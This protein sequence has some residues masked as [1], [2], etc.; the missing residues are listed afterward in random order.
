MRRRLCRWQIDGRFDGSSTYFYPRLRARFAFYR[1]WSAPEFRRQNLA[2]RLCVYSRDQLAKWSREHPEEKLS[3]TLHHP[4]GPTNSGP[5]SSPRSRSSLTCSLISSAIRRAAIRCASSG[6]S[7]RLSNEANS[8]GDP[9]PR[10]AAGA[11]KTGR[12][13]NIVAR[14]LSEIWQHLDPQLP[15]QSPQ[16]PRKYRR[17]PAKHQR[18]ERVHR[19]GNRDKSYE[20]HFD[21]R[22]TNA[23]ARRS[24]LSV[25]RCSRTS[26]TTPMGSRWSRHIMRW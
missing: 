1:S 26:P 11:E 23:P 14:G 10:S 2:S 20:K 8:G 24:R 22:P 18:H 13:R 3:G 7:M 25:R 19:L 12:Y 9:S 15:A 5:S 4:L 6:S 16:Y 17:Q 21:N